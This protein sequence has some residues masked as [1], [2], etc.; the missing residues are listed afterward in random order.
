MPSKVKAAAIEL[1]KGCGITRL[2]FWS[3]FFLPEHIGM[4]VKYNEQD[5]KLFGELKPDF[6]LEP[7]YMQGDECLGQV[8]AA[9][10]GEK[11]K[12][13]NLVICDTFHDEVFTAPYDYVSSRVD[14][15]Q[16]YSAIVKSVQFN[17]ENNIP[18]EKWA[19][20]HY[21]FV[22]PYTYEYLG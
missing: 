18:I 6:W 7:D 11:G 13:L 2:A 22:D 16:I 3:K 17:L 19:V 1:M 9:E 10:I 21:G 12:E 15:I 8:F 4:E 14:P 20:A 5:Q